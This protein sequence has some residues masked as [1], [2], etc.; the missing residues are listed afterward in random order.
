MSYKAI[1][2]GILLLLAVPTVSSAQVIF[3]VSAS[4]SELCTSTINKFKGTLFFEFNLQQLLIATDSQISNVIA[5]LDQQEI[6][7]TGLTTG[8]FLY[9][10]HDT[11]GIGTFSA[12]FKTSGNLMTSFTGSL[13]EISG[14][15][16]ETLAIKSGQIVP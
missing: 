2:F 9:T 5:T 7:V 8:A 16:A 1:L 14:G 11:N 6:F 15:C 13:T 3:Q 10:Q 12:T 4:G